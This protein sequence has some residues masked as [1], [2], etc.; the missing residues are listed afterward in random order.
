M[1]LNLANPAWVDAEPDLKQHI[2]EVKL[3]KVPGGAGRMR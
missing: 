1:P 3:P 2:V